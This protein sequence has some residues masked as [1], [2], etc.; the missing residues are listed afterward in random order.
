[1]EK[2]RFPESPPEPCPFVAV[3]RG[4]LVSFGDISRHFT[5]EKGRDLTQSY[6]KS[7]YIHRKPKK[8]KMTTTKIDNTAIADRLRTVSWSGD[9]Y[10]TGEDLAS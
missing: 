7:P 10:S 6:D 8:A 1:M 5:R 3:E 9:S 2:Q 4:S